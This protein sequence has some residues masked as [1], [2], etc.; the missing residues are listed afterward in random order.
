MPYYKIPNLDGGITGIDQYITADITRFCDTA[1]ALYSTLGKP[2]MDMIV[3]NYQLYRS[4]GLPATLLILANYAGST[5]LLRNLSPGFGRLAAKEAK[6]EGL[7]RNA[8][9]KLITNAE[10]IAFYKG[11]EI[12]MGILNRSFAKLMKHINEIFRV[13]HFEIK[14]M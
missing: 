8:H 1:A 13:R 7:Y 14:I 11:S 9:S 6:L 3:F 10:E 4:L 12:E 5:W 2:A